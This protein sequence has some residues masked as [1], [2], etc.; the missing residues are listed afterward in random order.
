MSGEKVL[1]AVDESNCGQK[2]FEYAVK[3]SK[4]NNYS[5]LTALTVVEEYSSGEKE[6]GEAPEEMKDEIE[7]VES[8]QEDLKKHA[9][10]HEV[11]LDLELK[12]GTHVADVIV[13][14]A[15]SNEYDLVVIG[16]HGKVE[17]ETAKL[18]SVSQSVARDAPMPVVV[19]T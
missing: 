6:S 16:S 2:A 3:K 8:L 13:D 9:E 17:M 19:I 12:K 18:G 7:R 15:E 11:E 5:K 10:D 4:E 1:V 14:F